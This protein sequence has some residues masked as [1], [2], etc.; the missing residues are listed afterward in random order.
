M[1]LVFEK[2][3]TAGLMLGMATFL[4]ALPSHAQ[5]S[6]T[7]IAAPVISESWIKTTVPGSAVSAAY[8]RIKSAIPFKLVKAES[9]AAGIVEIH[10]MKMN[11]GVMEMKALDAIDVPP[12]KAVELK[13]GGMHVMLMNVKKPIN[14]GDKIPMTLTFE[15]ANKKPVLVKLE[16]VAREN[17][18]AH[19]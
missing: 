14:K 13:P 12:N 16:L 10:D 15:G 3:A 9:T 1:K 6:A 2:N 19:H 8:M 17:A 4:L 7:S 11:D 18:T 5:P